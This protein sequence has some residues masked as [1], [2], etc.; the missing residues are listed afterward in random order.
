MCGYTDRPF[1]DLLKEMGA[2][3]VCTE[4]YASEAVVRGDPKA[5]SLM[6]F[7][8]ERPPVSVQIFGAKPALMAE[9]ARIV[10][11]LGASTVDLNMG[12]PA[13]KIV[14]SFSGSALLDDPRR[15]IE[16]VRAIRATI[17]VPF[18]VKMRWRPDGGSV[19]LARMCEAEGVDAVA[20]HGRTREQ[21]YSGQANWEWIA[22]MR[23]ALTIPVIGNGDIA[24]A[25]EAWR[26][27]ADTGCEAVMV[28]RALVG[29]P[30]L[31][32]DAARRAAGYNEPAS[33]PD[34]AERLRVLWRHGCL[35]HR[36]RGRK[37]LIEFRKHC[38]TY[39]KG[40]PHA[41]QARPALMQVETLDALSATLL[42]YYPEDFASQ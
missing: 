35:M 9:T 31:M 14:K 40:L 26:R 13:K 5:F 15:A 6:D 11:R 17:V 19:E 12:C 3:L 16:V 42:E 36:H 21:G 29:N 30:W 4:M 34:T 27:M 37:G 10:V 24:S 1:R 20:L 18:T 33:A 38:C 2:G 28:G 7:P 8:G 22:R 41:R 39:L 25:D 32:R 23:E